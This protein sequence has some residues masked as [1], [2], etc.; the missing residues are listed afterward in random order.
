M[1]PAAS[2]EPVHK[3]ILEG[4]AIIAERSASPRFKGVSPSGVDGVE[5]RVGRRGLRRG[6]RDQAVAVVPAE[7]VE[8]KELVGRS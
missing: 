8:A 5:G 2:G 4:A 3:L 1:S 7:Q 6:G